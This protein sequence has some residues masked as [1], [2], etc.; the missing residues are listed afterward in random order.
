[1]DVVYGAV[2]L[3]NWNTANVIDQNCA[4]VLI[5]FDALEIKINTIA[6]RFVNTYAQRNRKR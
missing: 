6:G 4:A 3:V 2:Y 5:Y 1:M